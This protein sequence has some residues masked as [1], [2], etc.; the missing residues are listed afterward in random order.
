MRFFS[1]LKYRLLDRRIWSGVLFSL[2]VALMMSYTDLRVNLG[3]GFHYAV[4]DYFVLSFARDMAMSLY[5][6]TAASSVIT[7][8]SRDY[9]QNRLPFLLSRMSPRRYASSLVLRL[10]LQSYFVGIVLGLCFF[11]LLCLFF[12]LTSANYVTV[13]SNQWLLEEGYT[14]F[15]YL[16]LISLIGLYFAF[17]TLMGGVISVFY[18]NKLMVYL[19]PTMSWFFITQF[20]LERFLPFFALPHAVL[21]MDDFL[22]AGLDYF[23]VG[24]EE[25]RDLAALFYPYIFM[26]LWGWLA[27][28]VVRLALV[29][30]WHFYD[31]E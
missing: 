3:V 14:L 28:E 17:F 11:G 12:P 8:F 30:H 19:F 31:K 4:A 23:K 20:R 5:I 29:K 6:L 25:Y 26:V 10:M 24:M 16:C 13:F 9:H 22:R 21:A 15:F 7:D 1:L 27:I 2:L 18:P